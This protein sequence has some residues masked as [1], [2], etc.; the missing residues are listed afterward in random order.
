MVNGKN[1]LAYTNPM[2][3]PIG[4]GVIVASVS[5]RIFVGLFRGVSRDIKKVV[6]DTM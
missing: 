4:I 5:R 2:I 6:E 3:I 1:V